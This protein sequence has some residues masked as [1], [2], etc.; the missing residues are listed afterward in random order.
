MG[1]RRVRSSPNTALRCRHRHPGRC[2]LRHSPAPCGEQAAPSQQG[3]SGLP[4][5]TPAQVRGSSR[6]RLPW[7]CPHLLALCPS[8]RLRGPE[9]GSWA[10]DEGP[11]GPGSVLTPSLPPH[12]VSRSPDCKMDVLN[13]SRVFGPTLVGHGSANPTPL[14]IMEDTPR[15]CKVR[16][17]LRRRVYPGCC[18][19]P[20]PP[21]LPAQVVAQL[22]S[23]PP[24]FW[25]GFV[26]TEQENLVP[27]PA[28]GGERGEAQQ[29]QPPPC[30]C[31]VAAEGSW[32]PAAGL[33]CDR[34][35][36]L[37]S[38]EPFFQPIAS[39]EPKPG[40]LSPAGTC[41]LPSTLRSC[42]GTAARPP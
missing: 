7:V 37:C 32:A 9:W 28:L 11:L 20:H 29:P 10:E 36:P 1:G 3:H 42:V 5:A 15:Q 23:L 33:G 16:G 4:H 12:R 39:P 18:Q 14:A 19:H 21:S 35:P 2:R 26:G 8:P 31:P 13:L 34:R 30:P 41:C 24:D 17:S 38:A 40:Q 27:T 22:L 25:R 6:H